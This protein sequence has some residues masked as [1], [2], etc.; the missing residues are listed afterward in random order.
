VALMRVLFAV[1]DWTTHWLPMV[2]LGWALQAAGHEVRVVCPPLQTAAALRAGLVPVEILQPGEL[3][4]KARMHNHVNARHGHW[5]YAELPPD[6]ETGRPVGSLDEFDPFAWIDEN[7]T[8]MID[9]ANHNADA[10][11]EFGRWWRPQ[12]VIHDLMSVE[13][14]LV[15]RVLGVPASLAL[16]GPVGPDDEVPGVPGLRFLAVDAGRAFARYQVGELGP[17]VIEHVIDPCPP[18]LGVPL[19]AH[20]LPMRQVPYN[21]PGLLPGWLREPARRT[22]VC[23]VWGTSVSAVFGPISFPV[24]RLV[25]A[26]ADLDVEVLFTVTGPDHERIGA[27]PPRMRAMRDVPLHLLLPTSDLVIH[28]G[29]GGSTMT[30]LAAGVPQLALPPGGDQELIGARVTAAGVALVEHDA[31]ATASSIRSAVVELLGA[32]GYRT[33]AARLRREMLDRP[34]PAAL[35]AELAALAAND[36]LATR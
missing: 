16:W 33:N 28:H 27:L 21:G 8:R 12:L 23:V 13:G 11:V 6:L 34:S 22:R 18:S 20:R 24:P 31:I 5:A 3:V 15:A 26:L 4:R 1:S 10:S 9:A 7:K 25:E 30:A 32:P 2:P 36:L 35:V 19:R 29:G 17:D 14:P